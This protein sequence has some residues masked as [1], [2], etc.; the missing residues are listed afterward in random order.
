MILAN[1]RAW[2]L[3]R[4]AA[5][6]LAWRFHFE[7]AMIHLHVRLLQHLHRQSRAHLLQLAPLKKRRRGSATRRKNATVRALASRR[8]GVETTLLALVTGSA[9][10]SAANE[11]PKISA[12]V[13]LLKRSCAV[14]LVLLTRVA[15]MTAFVRRTAGVNVVTTM[16]GCR[17]AS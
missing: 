8:M 6:T 1:H 5:M 15:A 2:Y 7:W 12:L 16:K 10:T 11:T 4:V 9:A 3:C 13:I 14:K 17:A